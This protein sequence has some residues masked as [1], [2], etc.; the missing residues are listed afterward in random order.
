MVN[1]RNDHSLSG[2]RKSG[3]NAIEQESAGSPIRI[4]IC[5]PHP[6]VRKGVRLSLQEHPD[7]QIAGECSR[8]DEVSSLLRQLSPDVVV[9][10]HDVPSAPE[11]RAFELDFDG[12]NF[13]RVILLC[14]EKRNADYGFGA[15]SSGI[16][17][18]FDRHLP[19]ELLSAAV[20]E[21]Y[22]GGLWF[23]RGATE[24]FVSAM[25]ADRATRESEAAPEHTLTMRQKRIVALV[26]EGKSNKEIADRVRVSQ[27]TVAYELT[28]IYR[29]VG[30]SDRIQLLLKM[31]SSKSSLE[32]LLTGFGPGAD[33]RNDE[34]GST[35]SQTQSGRKPLTPV[36]LRRA[37]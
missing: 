32:G 28:N 11:G 13:C 9:L 7:F 30:V 2:P 34:S 1:L 35:S 29:K 20:R 8:L 4:L 16:R 19:T 3:S 21:V 33:L 6:I 17:G 27:A 15:I 12:D 37:V 26:R 5:D 31:Q 25:L 22:K 23:D 10:G 24:S 36:Q 14:S 18:I